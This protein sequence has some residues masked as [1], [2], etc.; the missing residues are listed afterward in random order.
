MRNNVIVCI[1]A[2]SLP[3][4]IHPILENYVESAES[5]MLYTCV[6]SFGEET[7]LPCNKQ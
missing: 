1:I 6:I 4:F 5:G 7:N 2:A 3:Y